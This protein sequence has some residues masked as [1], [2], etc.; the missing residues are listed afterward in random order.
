MSIWAGTNG[1]LDIVPVKDIRR[2]EAEFLDFLGSKHQGILDGI[3]QSGKLEDS[4]IES[5]TAAIEEFSKSFQ[6]SEGEPLVKEAAVDAM[7]KKDEGQESITRHK[8]KPKPQT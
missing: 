3:V 4:T 7:D 8:P 1:F 5:L 2:F 6:T